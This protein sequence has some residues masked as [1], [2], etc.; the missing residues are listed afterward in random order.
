[1]ITL[2]LLRHAK[3]DWGA[4]DLADRDRPLNKRGRQAAERMGRYCAENGIEPQHIYCSTAERTR[5]TLDLFQKAYPEKCPVTFEES[6]YLA[7]TKTLLERLR[8]CDDTL[9]A[10]M[11]LAHNPGTHALA[12][13]LT[14]KDE[15]GL[16]ERLQAKF[17]TAALA[18]IAFDVNAWQD[19]KPG[20]GILKRFLTPKSLPRNA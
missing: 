1:M 19:V 18:E 3:S 17:P 9:S 10:V 20:K 5:Q 11:L 2:Y 15:C 16:A 14:G 6:L 8:Q 13:E 7:S 4:P 12:Y